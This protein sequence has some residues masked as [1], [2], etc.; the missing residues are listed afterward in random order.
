M[1]ALPKQQQTV[2]GKKDLGK[3][4]LGNIFKLVSLRFLLKYIQIFFP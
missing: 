2:T 3:N 4:R 1:K